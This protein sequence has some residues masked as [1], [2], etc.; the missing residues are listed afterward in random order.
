VREERSGGSGGS[1]LFWP[2]GGRPGVLEKM[3]L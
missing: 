1:L 2:S 3:G